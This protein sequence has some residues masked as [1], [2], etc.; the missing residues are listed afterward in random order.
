M[1]KMISKVH[2]VYATMIYGEWR[3]SSMYL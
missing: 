2:S 3:Y 1:G